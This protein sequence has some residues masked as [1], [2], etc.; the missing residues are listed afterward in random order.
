MKNGRHFFYLLSPYDIWEY[1]DSLILQYGYSFVID[2]GILSW[3]TYIPVEILESP[4]MVILQ[5][6]D[7]TGV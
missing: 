3:V 5:G 4:S 6:Y 2:Q 1:L 7:V